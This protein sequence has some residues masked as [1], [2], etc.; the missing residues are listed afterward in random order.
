MGCAVIFIFNRILHKLRCVISIMEYVETAVTAVMFVYNEEKYVGEMLSS[1]YNQKIPVAKVIVVDDYSTDRT[2][3]IVQEYQDKYTNIDIYK[4]KQK[5]KVF[6]YVTG[7]EQVKTEYFF[8]CAGDD[9]LLPNYVSH[10]L[11][12][13]NEKS[14]DFI[15][16]RYFITDENLRNPIE[17]KRKNVYIRSEIL[18]ANRVSGYLFGKKSIID[19]ILPLPTDV[20]FED[21]ITSLKLADKYAT[22]NLSSIPLFYYRKHQS[23]TSEKLKN[24]GMR[25]RDV[26]FITFLLSSRTI[27]LSEEDIDALNTRLRYCQQLAGD[28]SLKEVL[29]LLFNKDLFFIDRIRLILLLSPFIKDDNGV[30]KVINRLA[31]FIP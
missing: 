25:K 26:Q 3:K 13:I 1:I 20:S 19:I 31:R 17:N 30:Q 10:L 12:E 4:S 16:A 18:K 9:Y 29:H 11:N 24:V 22:V 6:A 7:L 8:I 21:W 14:L 28:T 5:G 23:S 2:L 15:Y 27:E